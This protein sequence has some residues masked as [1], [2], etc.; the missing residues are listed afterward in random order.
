MLSSDDPFHLI[1]GSFELLGHT[2]NYYVSD[3]DNADFQVVSE[4]IKNGVNEQAAYVAQLL[5]DLGF[6][7]VI[8]AQ[9]RAPS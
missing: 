9:S 8:F 2:N 7:Q 3:R 4:K 5:I 6:E 1:K